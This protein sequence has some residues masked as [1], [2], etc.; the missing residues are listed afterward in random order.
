MVVIV[1][2]V[3]NQLPLLPPFDATV[4]VISKYRYQDTGGSSDQD[5]CFWDWQGQKCIMQHL[6]WEEKK[7]N[8]KQFVVL[9]GH[10]Y[11]MQHAICVEILTSHIMWYDV[12]YP[13]LD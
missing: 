1:I 3:V 11:N 7:R 9:L 4:E 12:T 2:V 13:K 8:K 6:T 10:W 5:G